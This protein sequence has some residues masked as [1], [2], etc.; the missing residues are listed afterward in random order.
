MFRDNVRRLQNKKILEQMRDIE[1]KRQSQ[2]NKDKSNYSTEVR[3]TED[4][5]YDYKRKEGKLRDLKKSVDIE[6]GLTFKPDVSTNSNIK[7]KSSFDERNAKVLEYKRLL[8]EIGNYTP[9]H[10]NK[11]YTPNQIEENNKRVVER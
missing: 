10:F 5:Y 1:L 3:T 2:L 9:A 7:V 8:N 6:Q 11:K 4:L